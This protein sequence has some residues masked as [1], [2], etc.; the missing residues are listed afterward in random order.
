MNDAE[1]LLFQNNTSY[2]LYAY[3]KNT[4]K[5]GNDREDE[6]IYFSEEK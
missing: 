5:N 6:D 1:C 2:I 4:A 3:H